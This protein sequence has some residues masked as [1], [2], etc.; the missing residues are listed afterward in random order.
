MILQNGAG[1]GKSFSEHGI[2]APGQLINIK[3][4]AT[5]CFYGA[6]F[7]SATGQKRRSQ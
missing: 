4:V 7:L 5:D 6:P 3:T 1:N 2:T